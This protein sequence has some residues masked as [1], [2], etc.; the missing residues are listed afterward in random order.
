ML[1]L[2]CTQIVARSPCRCETSRRLTEKLFQIRS[3]SCIPALGIRQ[4][5][6]PRHLLKAAERRHTS[7]CRHQCTTA[8]KRR[9]TQ[10][11]HLVQ[12]SIWKTQ[13][14]QNHPR[15]TP[16]PLHQT[17]YPRKRQTPPGP[18]HPRHL[19]SILETTTRAPSVHSQPTRRPWA[20]QAARRQDMLRHRL[21]STLRLQRRDITVTLL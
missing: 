12:I 4:L 6:V 17:T 3:V 13:F 15:A 8:H 19:A 5:T 7:V 11:R 9:C 20:R 1:E 16:H 21:D 2:S 18:T 10:A 14:H